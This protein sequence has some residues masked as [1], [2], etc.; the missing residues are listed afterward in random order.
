M[1]EENTHLDPIHIQDLEKKY[2][3]ETLDIILKKYNTL[4]NYELIF[5]KEFKPYEFFNDGTQHNIIII[6]IAIILY[7]IV[8]SNILL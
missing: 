7:L 4:T 2:M 1:S 6:S 8:L 5:K 3:N